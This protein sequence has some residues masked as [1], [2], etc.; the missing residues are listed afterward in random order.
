MKNSFYTGLFVGLFLLLSQLAQAASFRDY[1]YLDPDKVVPAKLLQEAV[2]YYDANLDKIENQRVM[3][4]IDYKQHNS[5]ERFYIIDMESGRVERYLTAHGKN[6]DPDFDGYATKFSNVPDSNTTSLGFFL[7]AETYYGKNG[8]SLR[9][10]G[11]S[12]TNSNARERAIVIH[13]ADYV[14]PGPKIGRSYGCPAVEMRYHQELIDQIKG[15]ALL[16]AGL[17]L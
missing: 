3:G 17:G 4:V 16:Y 13:G 2:A 12:S 6:S 8:Y 10:D 1:S 14:T 9:L 5:K 15:G 7:T 11:L